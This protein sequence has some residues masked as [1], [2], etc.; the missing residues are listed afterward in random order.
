M[1]CPFPGD[2]FAQFERLQGLYVSFNQFTVCG[3]LGRFKRMLVV[4]MGVFGV[5]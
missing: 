3:C 1:S 2:L 4:V 5:R